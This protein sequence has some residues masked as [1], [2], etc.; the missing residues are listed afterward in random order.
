MVRVATL[1]R[2]VMRTLRV[3][4]A[5]RFAGVIG[6]LRDLRHAHSGLPPDSP[7]VAKATETADC[8][9]SGQPGAV[10]E[11]VPEVVAAQ[12]DSVLDGEVV[13]AG[14]VT[15]DALI[16]LDSSS[17][18]L[19]RGQERRRRRRKNLPTPPTPTFVRVGPGKFI[20]AEEVAPPSPVFAEEGGDGGKSEAVLDEAFPATAQP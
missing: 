7:A 18:P 10:P 15:E 9:S 3:L 1:K 17:G 6:P 20:R 8:D 11:T 5:S 16:P 19:E 12:S 4:S 14:H 13:E 2:L